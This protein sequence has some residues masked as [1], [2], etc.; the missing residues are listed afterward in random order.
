MD[1]EQISNKA[2]DNGKCHTETIKQPKR[3]RV[4]GRV[5]VCKVLAVDAS[6]ARAG[7]PGGRSKVT[8]S[9]VMQGVSRVEDFGSQEGGDIT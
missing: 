8:R 6:S 5:Q 1:S 4:T 3:N 7:V 9:Q 2:S